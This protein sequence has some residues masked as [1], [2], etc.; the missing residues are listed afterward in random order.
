MQLE[1]GFIFK[2]PVTGFTWKI[3]HPWSSRWQKRQIGWI[4]TRAAFHPLQDPM[5]QWKEC[6]I[7]NLLKPIEPEKNPANSSGAIRS[8]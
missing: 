4:C 7:I 5:S 8:N 3:S 1:P 6:D 2:D